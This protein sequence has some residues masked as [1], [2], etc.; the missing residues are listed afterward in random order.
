VNLTVATL[1][2]YLK[3]AEAFGDQAEIADVKRW[4]VYATQLP[5]VRERPNER[6]GKQ[7]R[8]HLSN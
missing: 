7:S 1:E 5:D 8:L 6:R 4:L 3:A 2:G